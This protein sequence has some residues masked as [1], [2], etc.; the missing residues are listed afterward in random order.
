MLQIGPVGPDE[1]K[2]PF[3]ASRF[4]IIEDSRKKQVGNVLKNIGKIT[5]K[6][7][8]SRIDTGKMRV[9]NE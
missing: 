6:W 7:L 2:T 9:K 5:T 1:R 3:D 4:R 8:Q